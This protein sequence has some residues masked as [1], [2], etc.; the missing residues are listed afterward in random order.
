[1]NDYE[2]KKDFDFMMLK[3]IK[4]VKE[5]D[6]YDESLV[7]YS[8]GAED[9]E[10]NDI[11]MIDSG[12]GNVYLNNYPGCFEEIEMTKNDWIKLAEERIKHAK[13][14]LRGRK[15]EGIYLKHIVEQIKNAE[16]II[17]GGLDNEKDIFEL[18]MLVSNMPDKQYDYYYDT[19]C[20]TTVIGDNED[21]IER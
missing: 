8:I 21:D 16:K 14:A 13:Y 19:P 17:L 15:I 1:M 12:M 9:Y 2:E 10:K 6:Y 4:N 18:L 5:A 3:C 7:G 20:D 11:F